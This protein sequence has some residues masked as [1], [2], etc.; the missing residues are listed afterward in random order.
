VFRNNRNKQKT[1]RN[2]SEFVKISKFLI[3]HTISSVCFGYFDTGPK[4]Q[5]KP[6]NFFCF[7]KKQIEKQPKQLECGLFRFEPRKKINGL[8]NL[9]WKFF[10]FISVSFNKV[11]F[12]SAVLILVRNTKTNRKKCFWVSQNK[13]KNNRH[14]LSFGL[15]Q[16]E[17][18]TKFDCFEDT[19]IVMNFT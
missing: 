7:T 15:F 16:F 10:W 12:V 1:N 5:N 9:F 19:L 17:P 3:P 4:H 14:R 2:S 11:L 13:P 18:K 8:E 6:I